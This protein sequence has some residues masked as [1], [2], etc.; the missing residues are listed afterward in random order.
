MTSQ[1]TSAAE[2]AFGAPTMIGR[3]RELRILRQLLGSPRPRIAMVAGEPGIGKTRLVYEFLSETQQDPNQPGSAT[4]VRVFVGQAEPGSL[5]RPYEVLLDALDGAGSA[6][7]A[8]GDD[9]AA[10]D[11][12]ALADLAN[13]SLSAVERLQGALRLVTELAGD[14]QTIVVFEDLHWADSESV[15]LF[16]RIADLP[17]RLVLVGTY[18]PDDV[19]YRHPLAPLLAR[20][21][22]RHEVA[23]LRLGRLTP[24]ETAA[25]LAAITGRPVPYRAAMA[26][27]QRTGGNPF[28]LEE[29]VRGS[30][31]SD[32]DELVDR[33]LPW[34]L[35]EAFRRQTDELDETSRAI[36]E[37]A[38]VL[39]H[40]V[41]FD[42]LAAVT[43]TREAEL[44]PLLRQLVGRG[45]LVE[46]G[47]DE[48]TF[49]HALVREAIAGQLLGRERR[50]LHEAALDTLLR[51]GA[52]PAL[53]A[54]HAQRAGRF[55]DMVAAARRGAAAYV[56]IGSPYQALE[57]AEIGLE[58]AC[59]DVA[60]LSTAA[61]AAWLAGL[62]DD[63]TSHARKWQQAARTPEERADAMIL[64]SRLMWEKDNGSPGTSDELKTILADLSSPESKARVMAAIAQAAWLRDDYE[65]AVDW[66]G[67]AA[68]LAEEHGCPSARL[69]ALVEMGGA[70]VNMP[71]RTAE[72]HDL[73][74]G[75]LDEAEQRG[76]WLIAS[77]IVYNLLQSILPRSF[78][79]H[80][81]LLER[82]R[83]NAERAG[84]EATAVAFYFQGRARLA[85]SAGDLDAAIEAI[86]LGRE[87]DRGYLRPGR[88]GDYHAVFLA[89]LYLEALDLDGVDEVL[90][91]LRQAPGQAP[92]TIP[93]IEFSLACRRG[94]AAEADRLLDVVFAAHAH[95]GWH[96]WDLA[97]DL[98]S[99]G[100][101]AGLPLD[102]LEALA[103]AFRPGDPT[104]PW[105]L[106]VDAQLSEARGDLAGARAAYQ[107]IVDAKE[108][109]PAVLATA[110]C[111][112]ARC[113]LAAGRNDEARPH[114]RS[115]DKLACQ[116]R[117]WRV[118][119][120][121]DLRD[122]LGMQVAD[123]PR[124]APAL[125]AREREVA[126]LIAAGL[127]NAELA[128]RLY[129]SPKTAAVHVSSILRKL[130]VSSRTEVKDHLTRTA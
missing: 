25:M 104:H 87:R 74:A 62:V 76:E 115:A 2:P 71:G 73:L 33:P 64:L 107:A 82:M 23:H 102:R 60:L 78:A 7:G 54:H 58:E 106:I 51:G 97:H 6:G 128:R 59:E 125:T 113:L 9:V 112:I 109:P 116:W 36:V 95:Q 32:L 30:D 3:D 61:R 99:A 45:V 88:R 119:Q 101:F 127:T 55:D 26:L 129:I 121:K 1:V 96:G 111:G 124:G 34:S 126:L 91:S 27:H 20:L 14:Q 117:G 70:L 80:A 17:L 120:I 84:H 22:R 15:T 122:R 66:A 5:A 94:D 40:R 79:E 77:R 93:A 56:D 13:P 42:L 108:L 41:P 49:R 57:L 44:I 67:R 52:D 19:T 21:D 18:R 38:A 65:A 39:G 123:V 48:F 46:A 43:E 28:F 103:A 89:G 118:D 83:A 63:A 98:L 10:V 69:A 53:V 114:V 68:A 37:A 75:I 90:D 16:E 29:L 11:A 130:G 92:M 47:E 72:G 12:D 50:R 35:A 31:N 85:M 105:G 110:E 8:L 81:Q 100:L 86:V 4:G 24:D